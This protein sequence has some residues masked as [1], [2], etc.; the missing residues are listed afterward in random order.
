MKKPVK[1]L[2]T[3]IAVLII[4]FVGLMIFVSTLDA[5]KYRPQLVAAVTKQTGRTA[6]LNGPISFSL[7]L[8]GVHVSIQD[9]SIA[10]PPW[11]SRPNL[12]GMG[13]F[14][15]SVGLL[16]L[17][18]EHVSL[19]EL[20]IENADILLETN[21]AGQH[22]WDFSNNAKAETPTT[23]AT[24]QTSSLS[25]ASVSI[26]KLSIVN[27]QLAMRNADG[28][29]SS[30]NVSSLTLDMH[31]AGANLNMTGDVNGTPLILKVKTGIT[32]LLSRAAFPFDADVTY[33]NLH[34][35]AKGNADIDHSKA[36]I[37]SYEL[38]AGK[39]KI[40]G[41]AAAT[42]NGPRPTVRGSLNSDHIDPADFKADK[43]SAD[44]TP[45][46]DKSETPSS[47]KR[48]FSDAPLPL[49][50]LKAADADLKVTV[51][52]FPMGK[53][54]LKQIS[55][56]LTLANGNLML[57]PVKA[58]VGA[59]PV[60]I[61]LKLDASQSPARLTIGVIGSSIDLGELQKLGNMSP[62]MTGS[63]GANIQLTGAGDSAHDIA[64]SLGGIITI[65]AE[66]GEVLGGAAAGISSTLATIF[67]PQGGNAA[68][69]CLAARFIAKDGVLKDNGIL[70]DTTPST[71][72]GNGSINLAVETVGLT[73]RAK[74][75]LVDVGGLVPALQISGAL[76]DPHYSVDAASLVKN[77]I[78]SLA[79]GNLDVVS[80]NAPE[81]QT[82]PAGQNACV[83]TL[84]HPKAASSSGILPATA[85]GKASQKIQNIGGSVLK[86]L[87]GK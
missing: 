64:S 40:N 15:I 42:W 7:G 61:Q 51:G 63:A 17:L 86:G 36:D 22:N 16:P 71:V 74:T 47:S 30:F 23:A 8:G 35:T 2:A 21:S 81:I 84:D 57:D 78:G 65:T 44:A 52:E 19:N 27:S 73:L 67:N 43:S 76:S 28:K 55:A 80:S 29:V 12:A 56:K 45:S 20:S 34:L 48:M 11:A 66:K 4:L 18:T 75:K 62:F 26:N 82:P 87:F 39:T 54:A 83:Y 1:I 10:N 32:N 13:K 69:N 38:A 72:V 53:G 49:S 68:L 77:V 14:E 9:A 60:S 46:S 37:T 79:G 59:S 85:A 3:V 33:N 70:I 31:G 41:D 6:K 25:S 58:N 5:D 24:P 50:G